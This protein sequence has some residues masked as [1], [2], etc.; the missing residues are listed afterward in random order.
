MSLGEAANADN[1]DNNDDDD[2]QI[3]TAARKR[4]RLSEKDPRS[5]PLPLLDEF[6]MFMRACSCEKE[7][8]SNRVSFNNSNA[9]SNGITCINFTSK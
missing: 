9:V 3:Q 1:E 8:I 7:D 2:D 6:A 5:E 4:A